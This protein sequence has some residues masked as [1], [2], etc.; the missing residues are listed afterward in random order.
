[1]AF[2][3][4]NRKISDIF[5]R[6]SIYS[7]PRYQR[8]YVWKEINWKELWIDL[9]FT[10]NNGDEI[11]WSHFLGTI[12]LNQTKNKRNGLTI[13]DIID[14]QQRLMTIYILL[15]SLYKNFIRIS[16]DVSKNRGE[17]IYNT[18]LTSLTNLA[19][20][21][22]VIDNE[23]YNTALK[24]IF[25]HVSYTQNL[26]K[27]NKLHTLFFYFDNH[28][29][30]KKIEYLDKFLD[31]VLSV[32]IVEI[33][34]GDDEEIYNIFEVLN[35]RG[36]KLKQIELLKNHI[37][38]YVKPREKA[39]IDQAK[40]KWQNIINNVKHIN[41]P[42]VLIQH[43]SKCYIERNAENQNSIYRL[44]KEEV[45][46]SSLNDF[47]NDLEFFSAVYKIVSKKD[48]KDNVIRYFNIKRN[49]QIRSLIC[50]IF[51]INKKGII[52]KDEA[53]DALTQIR[54]FFFIFNTTQ[55]TSNKTDKIVSSISYK[56]YH[57][58]CLNE[59]KIVFSEFLYEIENY[60]KDKQFIKLFE[61]NQSFK[62][63]TKDR[64]LKR[65]SRLVKYTLEM[66]YLEKQSDTKLDF[67]SLTIEHLK[68]DNASIENS[69]IWNLTLTSE[70]INSNYL[71][72]KPV[73]EK[74]NILSEASSIKENID[75]KKY[76]ISDYFDFEKRK[77]DL[78][79]TIFGKIFIFNPLIFNIS[80]EKIIN[81]RQT[82]KIII[83]HKDDELFK[84]LRKY[85]TLFEIKLNHDPNLIDAKNTYYEY[86]K[87][88]SKE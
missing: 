30:T 16:S 32:N 5:E 62:Y 7:V 34:S 72:N 80:K 47:L 50:A 52:G 42:D 36:Q 14:G 31:K 1:M 58:S 83:N 45:D 2:T 3:T 12:V 87:I 56:I 53:N 28:L 25:D 63:S 54:N 48:S 20:R 64:T 88:S 74:I 65:N 26:S 70:N 76:I 86:L 27:D 38:K 73:I 8:E 18:Y 39:F 75:L 69:S 55:Q 66:I 21:E 67:N 84:L 6:T 10:L 13:Y 85:G 59:F 35:A 33:I 77:K 40:N 22:L 43:F 23:Q 60:I 9:Q 29:K 15:I 71:K 4:E 17:F 49:Q 68:S 78:L 41:D 61:S 44:I 19:D 82:E 24:E 37:M 51:V 57:V 79:K 46:I 11:S 81:Y